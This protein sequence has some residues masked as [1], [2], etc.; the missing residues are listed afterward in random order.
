MEVGAPVAVALRVEVA[1][2]GLAEDLPALGRSGARDDGGAPVRNIA[3]WARTSG[4][5][6]PAQPRTVLSS[7]GVQV[8]SK[9]SGSTRTQ[10][11]WVTVGGAAQVAALTSKWLTSSPIGR[12]VQ[13]SLASARRPVRPLPK[14]ASVTSAA[15]PE[16]SARAERQALTRIRVPSRRTR[17]VQSVPAG[18]P[19]ARVTA[20]VS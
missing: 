4:A 3:A 1:V 13:P 7:S 10:S 17:I 16:G 19:V 12:L 6:E 11:P 15:H 9:G 20:E 18:T 2:A 8:P 14:V 5:V